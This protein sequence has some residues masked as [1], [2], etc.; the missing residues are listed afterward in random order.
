[1]KKKITLFAVLMVLL[2]SL[3][4]CGNDL[5]QQ[6]EIYGVEKTAIA[7]DMENMANVLISM[8]QET[9]AQNEENFKTTVETSEGSQKEQAEIIYSL[10][11]NGCSAAYLSRILFHAR[12]YRRLVFLSLLNFS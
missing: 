12:P 3:V 10:L 6:K 9:I 7:S 2:L 1:M 11:Q 4:A 5:N 8:D